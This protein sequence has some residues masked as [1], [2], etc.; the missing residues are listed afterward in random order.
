MEF[1]QLDLKGLNCPL[2]VMKTRRALGRMA[3]GEHLEVW[4]TDPMSQIDIPHMCN[5]DG[6]RLL[7]TVSDADCL[8]FRIVRGT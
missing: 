6:H 1:K 4:A 8:V 3:P 7:E 2:P 5:Q